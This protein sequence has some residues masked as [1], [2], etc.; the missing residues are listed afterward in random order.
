MNISLDKC[1][2]EQAIQIFSEL[3]NR[4]YKVIS[5]QKDTYDLEDIMLNFFTK[6][7]KGERKC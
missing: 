2:Y 5:Y 7:A 1:T 4:G 3:H 6:D